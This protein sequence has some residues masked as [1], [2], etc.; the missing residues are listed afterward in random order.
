MTNTQSCLEAGDASRAPTLGALLKSYAVP[1]RKRSIAQLGLTFGIFALTWLAMWLS[2]RWSY[3]VTLALAVVAAGFLVRLFLIQ[4][5]CGHGAFFKS[6]RA[7]DAVGRL[8]GVLTMTPYAYWKGI[9]AQHH[10]HSGNLDKRG[11][12]DVTTLT[13]AEF[14]ALPWWRRLGYRLYRNP[15]VMFGLGPTF[16]FVMKNRLP[17]DLPLKQKKLW[18]SVLGTNAAIAAALVGLAFLIGP[19]ALLKLQLPVMLGAATIGVWLFYI[20]HQF[21]GTY[22]RRQGEWQQDEA[23]LY[24]SSYYKL[25]RILHWLTAHIGLHHIH[26]LSSRIPNYRLREALREV[27]AIAGVHGIG[28]FQ[29]LRYA[30]L[31]LWD[32]GSARLVRFRDLKHRA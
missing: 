16:L 29:S 28:F 30:T 3:A 15:V 24:G 23:A 8:I 2:M 7:N 13:V 1:S 17:L 20:Q 25:P 12:G 27:P 32:E 4:H 11:I 26:H 22:W 6:R 18:L 9:H 14:L 5:D 10:A 31:S 19:V 21:D